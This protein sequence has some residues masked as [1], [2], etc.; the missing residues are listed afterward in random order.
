MFRYSYAQGLV[1]GS[2]YWKYETIRHTVD[3][4]AFEH[5]LLRVSALGASRSM[6]PHMAESE[7][8]VLIDGF[9]L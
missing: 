2:F 4:W 5:C 3:A 1:Y 9:D 7:E 8:W 6:A